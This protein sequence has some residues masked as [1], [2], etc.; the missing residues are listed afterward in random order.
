MKI[1]IKILL[2]VLPLLTIA[3]VMV[4]AASYLLASSSVN[5][6]AVEFFDFMSEEVVN[7]AEGQ[8]NLLVDNKVAGNPFMEGAAKLAVENFCRGILQ[9]DTQGIFALSS[10]TDDIAMQVGAVSLLPEEL[11]ALKPYIAQGTRDFITIQAGGAARVA[12]T[13]PFGPFGWQFF[14]TEER[15]RFYGPI[16]QIFRTSLFILL[17][18]A[19]VGTLLLFFMARYLTNPMEEVVKTMRSIIESSDLTE[20]VPVYYKDEVGQLST[21]FN[22]MLKT[23]SIAYEQIKRYALDAAIA[24]KRETKIRNVFQLYVPKDVIEEVFVN[25]EKMLIGNNRDISILFSDIRSFTTI[26]ENMAPDDLVNS[27][28]RYFSTMVNIIMDRSGVVDKYIGDAIMAIFGAPVSHGN[29][30]LSSVLTGLEMIGA[31]NSFNKA[32]TKLHAPE[33]RIGVGINFGTVTV[34]NIGCDKKMNYTVIGDAVN[35]ASRLE[36]LTKKYKEPVLFAESVYKRIKGDLPCKI[37]DRVAVKGKTQGVPIY[38]SCLSLTEREAEAW[39]YHEDAAELYYERRFEEA[40]PG[41]R[42]ALSLLPGDPAA[43]RFE[44][45][46]LAYIGNPPPASWDGVEIMAE[47]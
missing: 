2:V 14:I 40:L 28:N 47:K 29:D 10:T 46:C 13:I 27:L 24:Q 21:T 34:G 31:L 44:E 15:S 38:T 30:C 23:L 18:T 7:Y 45:R 35:L 39:K 37:I 8:W 25:P 6:L 26:S 20:T 12:Y 4:G 16:E 43:S 41:F 3:I 11:D 22:H 17:G 9:S 32:Q 5:R 33:F 42:K 36:G 19:A 1:R